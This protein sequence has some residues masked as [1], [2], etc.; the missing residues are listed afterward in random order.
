MKT[1]EQ[2]KAKIELHEGFLL[3]ALGKHRRLHQI[4]MLSMEGNKLREY[5][6]Q[7]KGYIEALKW[8]LDDQNT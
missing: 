7:R 2:I 8:I 5:I 4:D 1:P 3:E 6:N